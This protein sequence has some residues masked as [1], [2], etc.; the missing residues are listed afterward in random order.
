MQGMEEDSVCGTYHVIKRMFIQ[1]G[2]ALNSEKKLKPSHPLDIL[3]DPKRQ[4]INQEP[5]VLHLWNI[6]KILYKRKV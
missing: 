2:M 1:S 5:R 4:K 3:K 6:T